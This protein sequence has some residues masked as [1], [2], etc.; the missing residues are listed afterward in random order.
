MDSVFGRATVDPVSNEYAPG[1]PM[2]DQFIAY[3]HVAAVYEMV[4]ANG[5]GATHLPFELTVDV[6]A[7]HTNAFYR[8]E[9][10][11]VSF[12]YRDNQNDGQRYWYGADGEVVMHEVGHA[13]VDHVQ[14]GIITIEGS[15]LHEA[16]ADYFAFRYNED[17]C[18]GEYASFIHNELVSTDD[19]NRWTCTRTTSLDLDPEVPYAIRGLHWHHEGARSGQ[20]QVHRN[21]TAVTLTMADMFWYDSAPI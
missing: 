7:D 14:P 1:D 17:F 6:H 10:L 11:E 8:P 4:V 5:Y 15:M 12:G 20:L 21:S 2:L 9:T 19:P 3:H 13:I 16:Y 18:I